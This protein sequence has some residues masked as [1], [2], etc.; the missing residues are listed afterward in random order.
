MKVINFGSINI[1]HVYC[2]EHFVCPGETLK[3]QSYTIFSGGKGANQSIALAHANAKVLHAG[4]IGQDG[5]WLKEKLQKSGVDTHLVKIVDAPTGHAVIQVNKDGQNAIIIHGGANQ[6]FTDK[7]ID[8]VLNSAQAGDFLLLQNEINA[9]KK[10]LQKS[11]NKALTVV[12]NPAPMTETI[13]NYPLELVNIFIINEIEGE[14]L[15]EQNNPDE[16][17]S[18]MQKLYPK[19][20][21]VLTLGKDGVIYGDNKQ[22]IKLPALKVKAIDTTGAGDTFIGYFLAALIQGSEIEK[23]LEMGVKAS[24]LCVTRRGA[25][26]SIP[27]LHEIINL[28]S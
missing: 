23:C 14:A 24:S 25:A 26:D 6:T 21:I 20:R 28:T 15:T 9:V 3:S 16:I 1:D 5:V 10:I 17:L 12:F 19:S 8:T 13:K 7:D 2:V 22:R 18:A 4:K 27:K 11:K